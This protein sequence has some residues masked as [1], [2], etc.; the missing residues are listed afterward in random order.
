MAEARASRDTSWV[1]SHECDSQELELLE[2]GSRANQRC[3]NAGASSSNCAVILTR[4]NSTSKLEEL[5]LQHLEHRDDVTSHYF[6]LV[7]LN[8]PNS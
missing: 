8:G 3:L 5:S 2:R 4:S 6:I 1:C 7:K